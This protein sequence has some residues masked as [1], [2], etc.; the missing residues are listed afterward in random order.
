[1]NLA[2][3][4]ILQ[5]LTEATSPSL[6]RVTG[7][8][9]NTCLRSLQLKWLKKLMFIYSKNLFKKILFTDEKIFTI[10]QKFNKQN[11]NVYTLGHCTSSKQK[12]P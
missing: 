9:L 6:Q 5:V 10:E 7:H 11:D 2:L 4:T 3:R 1:M 8:L 12:F